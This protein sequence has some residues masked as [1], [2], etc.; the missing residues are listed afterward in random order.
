MWDKYFTNFV[1]PFVNLFDLS[2]YLEQLFRWVKKVMFISKILSLYSFPFQKNHLKVSISSSCLFI[3][4]EGCEWAVLWYPGEVCSQ[5]QAWTSCQGPMRGQ[6]Y[7][8]E[9]EELSWDAAGVRGP[10]D[11][12]GNHAKMWWYSPCGRWW[13]D[14]TPFRERVHYYLS[15]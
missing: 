9:G 4:W 11:D 3:E 8:E 14:N 10:G 1:S 15:F 5:S 2:Q 12:G 7:A 6:H 13:S